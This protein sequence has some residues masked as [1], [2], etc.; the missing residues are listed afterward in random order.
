MLTL[1]WFLLVG[2]RKKCGFIVLT[3]AAIVGTSAPAEVL[4]LTPDMQ[5]QAQQQ[6]WAWA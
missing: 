2:T 1:L 6:A 3:F 5:Q 4:A